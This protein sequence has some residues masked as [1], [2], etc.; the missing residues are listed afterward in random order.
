MCL[1]IS[2]LVLKPLMDIA[3]IRKGRRPSSSGV[4]IPAGD[5]DHWSGAQGRDSC[6]GQGREEPVQRSAGR[7]RTCRR[8]GTTTKAGCGGVWGC[9]LRG[10]GEGRVQSRSPPWPG[11]YE[12][13][14]GVKGG[15]NEEK[16]WA[17]GETTDGSEHG[18]KWPDSRCLLSCFILFFPVETFAWCTL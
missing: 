5:K 3:A 14:E 15:D 16:L 1:L 10:E 13:V 6:L 4:E 18:K 12:E 8:G 11:A 7:P 17:P 2:T 9:R